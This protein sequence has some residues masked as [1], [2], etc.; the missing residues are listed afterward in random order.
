MPPVDATIAVSPVFEQW[1]RWFALAPGQSGARVSATWAEIIR[2]DPLMREVIMVADLVFGGT[3]EFNRISVAT[4]PITTTSGRNGT[5]HS[6][7]AALIAEP[8]I[9]QEYTFGS[10]TSSAR[11]LALTIDGEKLKIND[12]IDRGG[13]LSGFAEVYLQVEG[14]DHDTRYVVLRGEIT[15]VRFGSQGGPRK[16][17]EVVDFEIVDPKET[18]GSVMP[19][20]V[21]DESRWADV[22]KTG[23]GKRYPIILNGY[24]V[25]PTIRVTDFPTGADNLFVYAFGHGFTVT[26]VFVNGVQ[27]GTLDAQYGHL[28]VEAIDLKGEP[29]SYI[30]FNKPG[31]TWADTDVVY[32]AAEH[33]G[34]DLTPVEALRHMLESFTPLG[35]QGTNTELYST[36]AAKMPRFTEVQVM[37]NGSGNASAATGIKWA[38]TGF[39]PSFPM[40]SMVWENGGYGPVLTDRRG[41]I[42]DEWIAGQHPCYDRDTLVEE[43]PK[44]NLFNR[45]TLKY[46]YDAQLNLFESVVTRDELNSTLCATSAQLIGARELSPIESRYIVG[47]ALAN[48]VAD[49]LVD[50]YAF[51]SYIVDYVCSPDVYFKR[52][53]GDL[54]AFTDPEFGWS[55]V[56]TTIDRIRYHRGRCIVTL[57]VWKRYLDIGGASFSYSRETG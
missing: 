32:V 9:N 51:P 31:T 15:G 27:Y 39:L 37:A 19:V 28:F 55:R 33:A 47:D 56:P 48:Y 43:E 18:I 14:G 34:D 22:H 10:G 8:E 6:A 21:V 54:I 35:T 53:R 20:W 3:A 50:H 12:I 41:A 25:I 26:G 49:W 42:Q 30:E 45:F 16:R 13:M 5:D 2:R 7:V 29:V 36:A 1:E 46:N 52:R 17:N 23:V 4:V 11:S 57:R 44:S 24:N 40:I 38:E